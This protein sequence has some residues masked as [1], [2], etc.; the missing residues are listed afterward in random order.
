MDVAGLLEKDDSSRPL[1]ENNLLKIATLYHAF[2]EKALLL[3]KLERLIREWRT[4]A[5]WSR[6]VAEELLPPSEGRAQLAQ[7]AWQVRQQ[8]IAVAAMA[9]QK[10][11]ADRENCDRCVAV[12]TLEEIAGTQG[13]NLNFA[14]Y[15]S[16]RAAVKAENLALK[17]QEI[18]KLE[19]Q[20]TEIEIEMNRLLRKLGPQNFA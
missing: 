4:A 5:D 17:L 15:L 13:H 8:E 18:R 20:R 9:A 19:S 3:E 12:A 14:R 1:T 6:K 10:W 16:G 2:G 7:T 11:L